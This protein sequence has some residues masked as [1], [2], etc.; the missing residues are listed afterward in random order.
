MKSFE[1]QILTPNGPVFNGLVESINLP[2][3]QGNFQVLHNHA[4]LMSGLEIG[5][6]TINE[7]GSN[8]TQIA[9]STGF[10]EVHD[11]KVVV[12]AESAEKKEQI[13]VQRAHESKKR[14]E[15]RLKSD[16]IDLGRAEAA[17]HRAINRIKLA[18]K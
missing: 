18:Q 1:A 15:E 7:G 17:L 9:V 8:T 5:V 2:G 12:L 16:N 4:S 3:T 10:V 11:N 6:V 13:D 14:A